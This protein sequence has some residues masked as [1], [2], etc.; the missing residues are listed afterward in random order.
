MKVLVTGAAGFLGRHLVEQLGGQGHDAR[1]MDLEDGGGDWVTGSVLDA[2]AVDRA[3]DGVDLVLHGAAITDLWT[4]GRFDY[5]RVN[6]IGTCRVLA[7]ARR[8][9]AR[10]VVVSSYTTLIGADTP[11][12]AILDESVEVPPNRLLGAYPASKRQAE[13]AALSAAGA[14]QDVV[15]VLPG[16]P[17]GA[18]DA[19]PT[20]PGRLIADLMAGR[21]P[22]LLDC[23][24]NLVDVR[25]VARA[26]IAAGLRG[27]GGARYLLTGEDL[28]V[29]DVAR[30]VAAASGT[31]APTRRVP[32]ALAW[33]AAWV[34]AQLAR[35]TGRPPR[36]PMT[37]VRLA[38]R[39]CRFDNARARAALGFAPRPVTEC[40]AEAVQWYRANDGFV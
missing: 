28:P 1:G 12:D 4:P 10:T 20:P 32:Y 23:T 22:A 33:T 17:I 24:L 37:G 6:V 34:E 14:G 38:G 30:L 7:A 21:L 3:V 9:G 26:T 11:R 39:P 15:I 18:G 40:V 27:E 25:A 13:L 8:A 5:D 19:R 16:A 35:L 31:P 36:A 29:S 2:D